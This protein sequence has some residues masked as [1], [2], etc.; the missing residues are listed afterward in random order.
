MHVQLHSVD[1]PTPSQLLQH[2]TDVHLAL[3]CKARPVLV[4]LIVEG[5]S[6]LF[7]LVDA[8]QFGEFSEV[9]FLVVPAKFVAVVQEQQ[10]EGVPAGE[11]YGLFEGVKLVAL[12]RFQVV[13]YQEQLQLDL[14]L[15]DALNTEEDVI[16]C[17]LILLE[18]CLVG[19]DIRSKQC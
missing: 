11:G 5:P 19:L 3:G 12:D 14:G 8:V 16:H 9:G 13:H 15:A 2:L 4:D 18:V 6:L 10:L 17:L 7:L 1:V